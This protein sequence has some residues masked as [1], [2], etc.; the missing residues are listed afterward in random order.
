MSNK[1]NHFVRLFHSEL[2]PILV[3]VYTALHRGAFYHSSFRW[4]YHYGSN[5]STR[6]ETEKTQ[7]RVNRWFSMLRQ[8]FI[9][10]LVQDLAPL[11]AS[12]GS[13]WREIQEWIKFSNFNAEN[14]VKPTSSVPLQPYY[15]IWGFRQC[16]PFS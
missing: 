3:F 8:G 4:I 7:S 12:L 13:P 15:G 14:P 16:L 11:V 1:H 9:M 10:Y 6:K 2:T 5:E